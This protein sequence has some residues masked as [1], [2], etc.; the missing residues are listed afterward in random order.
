ME[1][2][3][4]GRRQPPALLASLPQVSYL[5]HRKL[6]MLCSASNRQEQPT[7]QCNSD[8]SSSL[9]PVWMPHR[10]RNAMG[11]A[12]APH[13]APVESRHCL[14]NLDNSC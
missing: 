5:S 11:G 6:S 12:P 2:E 8:S 1:T 7:H 10:R 14:L 4:H 9:M 3:P 13:L